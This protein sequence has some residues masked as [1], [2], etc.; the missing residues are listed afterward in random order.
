MKLHLLVKTIDQFIADA[1][2]SDSTG[3]YFSHALVHEFHTHWIAPTPLTL[4][5][6]YEVCLR[7]AYSQ[8]WWKR[9]HYRPKEIMLQLINADAELATIAWKDLSQD[10]ASLEGRLSRFEYY[11][12]E[13]LQLHRQKNIRSVETHHHQ[14]ASIMS[15]YLAGLFPEKYALYPGLDSFQFFCK[16]IGSPEIPVVDDLVR[17]MKVASIVYS[18]LLKS[19]RYQ[20][21]LQH[22]DPAMHKVEL[23]SFQ[24]SYEVILFAAEQIKS[25]S[26]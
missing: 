3:W 18:Y 8:R 2:Q 26:V 16:A 23:I 21:L 10:S 6:T 11:C 19:S 5:D 22:R 25:G 4:K 24:M 1:V 20:Q 14:D 13:L 7:S 17:Y 9:D 15:L 12:S